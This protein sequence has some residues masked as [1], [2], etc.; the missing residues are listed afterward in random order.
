[1]EIKLPTGHLNC[2]IIIVDKF[3]GQKLHPS[4]KD[5][6]IAKCLNEVN[7]FE[8]KSPHESLTPDVFRKCNSYSDLYLLSKD[9]SVEKAS[10]IMVTSR[11]PRELLKYV[12][13]HY[14]VDEISEGIYSVRV[15]PIKT[16]IILLKKIPPEQN[17]WITSLK[18]K[19]PEERYN[20]I[21]ANAVNRED[22][23]TFQTFINTFLKIN[24]EKF[25]EGKIKM[26]QTTIELMKECGL[27][28]PFIKIGEKKGKFDGM[29][30]AKSDAIIR[31]LTKRLETPPK[32]LQDKIRKVR[33]IEKLDELIEFAA[34]CVSIGEFA[35]ALN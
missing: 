28:D 1:M 20:Q 22:N 17:L 30:V 15:G 8:Y 10:V 5:N 21:I 7:F 2:D 29:F 9:I 34:T 31:V 13:E 6:G 11:H 32:K 23:N 26:H 33:S 4:L 18:L 12:K 3:T 24:K 16:Y 19:L 25:I 27:A 35:T 14:D